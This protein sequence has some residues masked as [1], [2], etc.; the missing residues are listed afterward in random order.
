MGLWKLGMAD[1]VH[2]FSSVGLI[3]LTVFAFVIYGAYSEKVRSMVLPYECSPEL[4][5]G[6]CKWSNWT[7]TCFWPQNDFDASLRN[8]TDELGSHGCQ[9]PKTEFGSTVFKRR[10][11]MIFSTTVLRRISKQTKPCGACSFRLR[12]WNKAS[13]FLPQSIDAFQCT[14]GSYAKACI[15]EGLTPEELA[16]N[17]QKHPDWPHTS[18][19]MCDFNQFI[20]LHRTQGTD[21]TSRLMQRL[22]C[23]FYGTSQPIITCTKLANIRRQCCGKG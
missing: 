20:A 8:F 15:V 11:E 12:C 4:K 22:M 16:L 9:V 7:R 10:V 2:W 5:N 21:A 14:R 19:D 18:D 3:R 17:R 1:F 13:N 6:E 23:S